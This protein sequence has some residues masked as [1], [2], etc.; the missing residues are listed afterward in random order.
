MYSRLALAH[1]GVAAAADAAP[2]WNN[3]PVFN[4]PAPKLLLLPNLLIGG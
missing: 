1:S 4:R 2:G 3:T